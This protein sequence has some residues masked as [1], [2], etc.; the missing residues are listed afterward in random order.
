MASLVLCA[1]NMTDHCNVTICALLY[2]KES[3]NLQRPLIAH[4]DAAEAC[5]SSDELLLQ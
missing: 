5:G 4:K 2:Y 1:L 3:C